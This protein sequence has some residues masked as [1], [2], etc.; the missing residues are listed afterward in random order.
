MKDRELTVLSAKLLTNP[1]TCERKMM[2]KARI[3][4]QIGVVLV[5]A[6]SFSAAMA[7]EPARTKS[8]LIKELM[9]VMEI[10]ANST[11]V[12]DAMTESLSEE[13]P[14]IIEGIVEADSTLT[15][16][17]RE[18]IR[19]EKGESYARFMKAFRER[20]KQRID[21]AKFTEEITQALYDK[22]FTESE[23]KDLIVFYKTATGKKSL[24]IMP[25]LLQDSIRAASDK[26]TPIVTE[27]IKELV[28]EE[29]KML[30]RPR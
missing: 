8:E 20:I 24:K 25:Q 18:R 10:G 3:V 16:E 13:Y 15:P 17:T 26:L 27:L 2:K 5:T 9:V 14:R 12:L 21:F 22:Y 4:A 7:Q 6:L 23:I 1:I 11:N 29:A 19:N 30:K 28:E